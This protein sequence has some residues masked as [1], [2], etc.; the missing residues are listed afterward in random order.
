MAS[1]LNELEYTH[2]WGEI[3]SGQ[4]CK[5]ETN[6]PQITLL[7]KESHKLLPTYGKQQLYSLTSLKE[8]LLY[9]L[10]KC[11]YLY[12]V[13]TYLPIRYVCMYVYTYLYVSF[14][15]RQVKTSRIASP[16]KPSHAMKIGLK[17]KSLSTEL[18]GLTKRRW[19]W[20]WRPE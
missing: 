10:V 14:Q 20:C 3:E 19:R 17:D 15:S 13:P 4:S 12:I 6:W 5:N 7:F 2:W 11:G 16:A 9:Y 8:K 1:K 18:L